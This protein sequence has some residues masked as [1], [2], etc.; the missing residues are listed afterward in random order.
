MNFKN[1]VEIL[2]VTCS[3]CKTNVALSSK[4]SKG[5][6]PKCHQEFI[7]VDADTGN[8]VID[9]NNFFRNAKENFALKSFK[10]A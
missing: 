5:V 6:C 9:G 4:K 7:I 3:S 8:I 10:N 1:N 2:M